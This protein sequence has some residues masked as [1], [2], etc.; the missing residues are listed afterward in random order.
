MASIGK[1][2]LEQMGD[3]TH[4][5]YTRLLQRFIKLDNGSDIQ[6]NNRS[7]EDTLEYLN[8]LAK[9]IGYTIIV[10]NSLEKTFKISKRLKDVEEK[11]KNVPLNMQ[12][13]ND[14]QEMQVKYR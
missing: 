2:S 13:F 4:Q 12:M 1:D 6:D 3:G 10:K 8:S 9:S 7:E 5:I 11:M 14:P